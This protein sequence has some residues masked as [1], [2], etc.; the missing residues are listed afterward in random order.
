MILNHI[1]I[2]FYDLKSLFNKINTK[3]YILSL[4]LNHILN[5]IN[6]IE[7]RLNHENDRSNH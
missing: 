3:N 2:L 6:N 4:I 5:I 1:S 7:R